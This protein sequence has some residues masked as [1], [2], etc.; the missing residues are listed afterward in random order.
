M[1]LS[2]V[3]EL[4]L[5]FLIIAFSASRV[6]ETPAKNALTGKSNK[7][8]KGSRQDPLN[9]YCA[10][11]T[12]QCNCCREFSLPVV[13][14]KGPGCASIRYVS[15]DAMSVSMSFGDRVLRNVTIQG[16]KPKPVC[17]SLPGG[18]SKFC[19][20]VYG[21]SREKDQF[22]ACLG[23]ELRALDDVEAALR[24]SCFR[25]G[26]QGLNVEPG[27]PVPSSVEEEDE[28]DD[29]YGLT[30][31]DD[32]D[33]EEK[34]EDTDD[35]DAGGLDFG[36]TASDDEEEEEEEEE[37]ENDVD[38][39]DTDY[40]GFSALGDDFF[41]SIFGSAPT[42]KKKRPAI[43]NDKP[44]SADI[45]P[46]SPSLVS[47]PPPV[48]YEYVSATSP[49]AES[50]TEK[51]AL[52][53]LASVVTSDYK[54]SSGAAEQDTEAVTS[55]AMTVSVVQ[56][57]KKDVASTNKVEGQRGDD[58]LRRSLD[59]AASD[60]VEKITAA[61]SGIA[62]TPEADEEEE[63]DEEDGVESV[64]ESA[65]DAL[66]PAED[67]EKEGEE[68][69]EDEEEEEEEEEEENDEAENTSSSTASSNAVKDKNEDDDSGDII[70]DILGATTDDED[71]DDEKKKDTKEKKSE[72]EK[73][74]AEEEEEEEEA[75][76]EPQSERA[77]STTATSAP[78]PVPS[79]IY[80]SSRVHR[81]MR[82]PPL[83][84]ETKT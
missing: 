45:V 59:P 36:L 31:D 21:I 74:E 2:V 79:V 56:N 77:P 1:R 52:S 32:D 40:T 37:A 10:C 75:A 51:L 81:R 65:V 33:D 62:V 78:E 19:G 27:Q 9:R 80:R 7:G 6:I 50:V 41:E 84:E 13:P 46:L 38:S 15:G 60:K 53:S 5:I 47:T 61:T 28:D 49:K 67:D 76:A 11:T 70:E 66:N 57:S 44:L 63:D 58:A 30:E 12:L 14:V 73:K 42:K 22:K 43:L 82:L 23:L 29:D 34:D 71:D 72:P 55:T 18:I 25:F 48:R 8:L 54:P 26:P 3:F 35:D 20:R 83:P 17:M 68:K 69:E 24:V 39:G 64:V 4:L 16:K